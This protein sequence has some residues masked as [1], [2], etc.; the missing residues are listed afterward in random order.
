MTVRMYSSLDAGAPALPSLSSQRFIDNLKIILRACLVDGYGTKPAAGWTIGHEHADGFSLSNGEG[1]INFVHDTSNMV[2]VYLLEVI[3]DGSTALAAGIN[4]RSGPWFEGEVTNLR[5]KFFTNLYSTVATKSWA[6][7]ADDKTCTFLGQG[8]Y[9]LGGTV[10]FPWS[11][12]QALHFGQYFPVLGGA[13]FLCLGGG[14]GAN[15]SMA[16]WGGG[17]IYGTTLRHPFTGLVDQGTAPG[18]RLWTPH[19]QGYSAVFSP[20]RFMPRV[21]QGVRAGVA[22]GGVGLSGAA[23][24]YTQ[25]VFSGML[26]GLLA[27]P[28]MSAVNLSHV[29]PTLGVASP[30]LDDRL[31]ALDVG[32]KALWPLFPHTG[33]LGGFVSLDP[34]DW[35]PLWS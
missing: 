17:G 18:Y 29:L 8:N 11:S 15:S 30:V 16:L 23:I 35:G 25:M 19:G 27:E 7:V 3:T 31:K 14:T 9:S 28:V 5:H 22:G 21:F 26:R 13:G 32:G 12:A 20:A 2:S 1:F 4:R 10:D 33:D 34:E 6:L 24:A